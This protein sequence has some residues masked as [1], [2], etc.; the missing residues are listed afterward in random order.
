MTTGLKPRLW[1]IGLLAMSPELGADSLPQALKRSLIANPGLSAAQATTLASEEGLI[2]AKRQRLPTLDISGQGGFYSDTS[3][4]Q[5][6]LGYPPS[7]STDRYGLYAW[8]LTLEQPLYRGGAIQ[9]G[10]RKASAN[11]GA[12]EASLADTRQ[13]VLLN[14]A[15]AYLD[16]IKARADQR[17]LRDSVQALEAQR[18]GVA[19]LLKHGDLTVVDLDQVLTRLADTQAQALDAEVREAQAIADYRRWVGEAP[20]ELIPPSLLVTLPESRE[21]A[22]ERALAANPA[23][24]QALH[25]ERAAS[26][27]VDLARADGK[28]NLK[29]VAKYSDELDRYGLE[30]GREQDY[31][32]L[33]Q[34][35]IPLDF[36]G[37]VAAN[38][39]SVQ[40]TRR[41]QTQQLRLTQD[42]VMQA[43]ATAWDARATAI[44]SWQAA[45]VQVLAARQA[46]QGLLREQQRGLK[47]VLDTLNGRSD[48]LQAQ[49]TEHQA[50]YALRLAEFQ[51]LAALG[52]LD[53]V[54]ATAP[55]SDE[56]S[57]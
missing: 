15:T 10:I 50:S 9:A 39:A 35:S 21:R 4:A 53:E 26:A 18:A 2:Q 30:Q 24:R 8:D 23:L 27:A 48:L 3:L 17:V 5:G 13:T 16:L 31:S 22:I 55:L 38:V 11:V 46:L 29:L 34:L 32:L 1:W 47:T 54:L 40:E 36:A 49:L 19:S 57:F 14:A 56:R 6:V 20:R 7:S 44:A 28:P 41:Q 12:Q 42:Q 33:L 52:S 43:A 37:T 51:L 45:K 25:E